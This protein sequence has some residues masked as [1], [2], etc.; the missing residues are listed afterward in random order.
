MRFSKKKMFILFLATIT[1]LSSFVTASATFE[2]TG[3]S[4]TE[5]LQRLPA[6][7]W[8]IDTVSVPGLNGSGFSDSPYLKATSQK[9]ASFFCI[10]KSKDRNFDARIVNSNRDSR[11]L[12]ARDLDIGSNI[13]VRADEITNVGYYYYCEV[14]SDLLTFGSVDVRLAYAADPIYDDPVY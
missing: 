14:S 10:S 5:A 6:T 9:Y 11:S 2:T 8:I 4:S 7:Y 12:W 13:H 3:D 1:V